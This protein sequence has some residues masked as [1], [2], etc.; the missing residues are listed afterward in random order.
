MD[1]AAIAEKQEADGLTSQAERDLPGVSFA[2]RGWGDRKDQSHSARLGEVLRDR[3]LESV[4]LVH[5]KLGR[6]E[7]SASSG[8]GVSA[9][10]PWVETMEQG[11]AVWHVGALLGVPRVLS[12][13][14]RCSRSTLIGPITLDVKCAGARRAGNPHATCDVAGA[15]D[16]AT[17]IPKRA[18][19]GKP[20][21]QAKEEPTGHRASARP[22]RDARSGRLSR[23]C[24]QPLRNGGW[25][26]ASDE[27]PFGT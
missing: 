22:Y 16:G 7:D 21:I 5:P 15:G 25:K 24:R 11:M 26:L 8:A 3:P 4:L 23:G 6:D 18:R 9:S 1:A 14:R 20:R 13:L 2:A 10:R 17:A 12:L 19:R 27:N